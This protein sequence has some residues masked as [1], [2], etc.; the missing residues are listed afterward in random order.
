MSTSWLI[1]KADLDLLRRNSDETGA[2]IMAG[3]DAPDHS[4][5]IKLF[6][7]SAVSGPYSRPDVHHYLIG[8]PW[9]WLQDGT[10]TFTIE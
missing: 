2:A 4:P 10:D 3:R 5:V 6:S 7:V 8:A 1:P 9:P